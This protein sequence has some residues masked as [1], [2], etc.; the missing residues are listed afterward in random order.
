MPGRLKSTKYFNRL[1]KQFAKTPKLIG[2]EVVRDGIKIRVGGPKLSVTLKKSQ[3]HVDAANAFY[4]KMRQFKFDYVRIVPV[5]LDSATRVQKYFHRPSLASL[6]E[7][8]KFKL[9][10]KLRLAEFVT[11]TDVNYCNALIR[12]FPNISLNDWFEKVRLAKIELVQKT[13]ITEI[14]DLGT[15]FSDLW[16]FNF[17][18]LIV[19]GFDSKGI[20]KC[21]LVDV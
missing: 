11:P 1:A 4:K 19:F 8:V 18:N 20:I 7:F 10:Y 9:N 21:G 14:V 12:K 15:E 3:L 17:K 16:R 6:E 13:G 5:K 2:K